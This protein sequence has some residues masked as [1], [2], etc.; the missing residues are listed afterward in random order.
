M[1][2][3]LCSYFGENKAKSA[4]HHAITTSN[5]NEIKRIMT[6]SK[7]TSSSSFTTPLKYVKQICYYS[8][9]VEDG[10][11]TE[12][13]NAQI[14]DN[15]NT[16]LTLSIETGQVE[17][18]KFLL[19]QLNADPN[20]CNHVTGQSP[21]HMLAKT[22]CQANLNFKSNR[23]NSQKSTSNAVLVS[24]PSPQTTNKIAQTSESKLNES[25]GR[26]SSTLSEEALREM[27]YLLVDKGADLNKTIQMDIS[28]DSDQMSNLYFNP[29]M[30]AVYSLNFI[31]VEELLNL[32]CDCNFQEKSAKISALHLACYMTN[33]ELVN[34]ILDDEMRF[35]KVSLDLKSANGCHCLHWLAMSRSYDD[36]GIFK[37]FINY[38]MKKYTMSNT[39]S[40]ISSNAS[41]TEMSSELEKNLYLNGLEEVMKNFLDQTNNEMQTPLMI[42]SLNNKQHLVRKIF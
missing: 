16:P 39:P 9:E 15:G 21:L 42:A 20:T 32:G 30:L 19:I 17:S 3:V 28:S 40:P 18:F 26:A 31:V 24:Q 37:L 10:C 29:L 25:Q 1:G 27:V 6:A 11:G 8:Q 33:Y 12:L 4:L 7:E 13:L 5:T 23:T 2:G 38:I 35:I 41:S 22:K 14:D 36:V 34:L